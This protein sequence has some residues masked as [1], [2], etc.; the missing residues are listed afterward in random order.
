MAKNLSSLLKSDQF[1]TE[2]L[3]FGSPNQ[4]GS[5]DYTVCGPGSTIAAAKYIIR[6][7]PLLVERYNINSI[8]DLACGDYNWMRKVKFNSDM[9]Y[10]G[11]DYNASMI[12]VNKARYPNIDF[13]VIDA[14]ND[15]IPAVDLV[16]CR[17]LFIHFPF[18]DTKK[19]LQNI[20]A[21]G[22]KYLL[23]TTFT[24]RSFSPRD[25]VKNPESKM[26]PWTR[27]NLFMEP[28]NM[29]PC[30]DF[31]VEF[32]REPDNPNPDLNIGFGDKVLALWDC[33][34]F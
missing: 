11:T 30:L 22:A 5:D 34:S 28:F 9:T 33:N 13:R 17:D 8:L 20:K 24:W 19:A 29:P 4:R 12:E 27:L 1:L 10:I 26:T 3:T 15:P 16:F 18:E 7:L 21:S 25:I 23:T 14:V 32:N 31:I 6:E 2:T